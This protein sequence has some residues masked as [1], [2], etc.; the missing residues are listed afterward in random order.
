MRLLHRI[1]LLILVLVFLLTQ[2]VSTTWVSASDTSYHV[3]ATK[4]A[5]KKAGFSKAAMDAVT[6]GE[7]YADFYA[8]GRLYGN[9]KKHV[10]E[11]HFD[12]LLSLEEIEKNYEWLEKLGKKKLGEMNAGGKCDAFGILM[13]MG[14]VFHAIQDFYSH[15]NW[16]TKF[17][18]DE[19]WDDWDKVPRSERTGLQ[20]G[21]YPDGHRAT[22]KSKLGLVR[23]P[24]G[25][26]HHDHMHKDHA[27]RPGF[28]DAQAQAARAK[29]VWANKFKDWLG[30]DAC[31]EKL[32]TWPVTGDPHAD[33]TT[34]SSS[35]SN[36]SPMQQEVSQM[37]DISKGFGH[38]DGPLSGWAISSDNVDK[39]ANRFARSNLEP[40]VFDGKFQWILGQMETKT[41]QAERSV[42]LVVDAS[43]SM[44][45]P[46]PND[47]EGKRKI[48]GAKDAIVE[49]LGGLSAG[50]EVAIIAYFSCN[51]IQVQPFTLD[52]EGLIEKIEAIEPSGDT[53]MFG[54]IQA[55]RTLVESGIIN[56]PDVEGILLSDGQH[57]CSGD[58]IE[59]AETW[60]QTRIDLPAPGAPMASSPD[61]P[62]AA[63][64]LEASGFGGDL[65]AASSLHP[66]ASAAA[67][68]SS[69]AEEFPVLHTIGFGVDT[70]AEEQLRQVA[71]AGGGD[72]YSAA[73]AQDLMEALGQAS[74][75]ADGGDDVSLV[76]VLIGVALGAGAFI[77]LL[78]AIRGRRT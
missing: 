25:A 74:R 70:T 19:I 16:A 1:S 40:N 13:M 2:G 17:M 6:I 22:L 41:A 46:I 36:I 12:N 51:N 28:E 60:H 44:G 23:P 31:W 54:S 43:G 72:Y 73:S 58:P 64:S 59:A 47:P 37:R 49:M 29:E 63:V 57:N 65:V 52:K 38:W 39:A 20:T 66:G 11:L 42:I 67:I 71:A 15:S 24:A 76:V 33:L 55:A 32:K 77:V 61:G 30:D 3:E 56:S 10:R 34:P 68:G 5:L 78:R 18:D 26:T 9:V 48:D 21:W 53:D 45:D 27:G 75:A 62:G 7:W 14:T 50:T 8:N 4:E 69:S 35:L